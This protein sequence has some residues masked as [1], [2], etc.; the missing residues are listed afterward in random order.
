MPLS[1]Y[2]KQFV[3]H[4]SVLSLIVLFVIPIACAAFIYICRL[5]SLIG[6]ITLEVFLVSW[7]ML[8]R[9]ADPNHYSLLT[10]S[11]FNT[12]NLALV[13]YFLIACIP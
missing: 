2:I 13:L 6:F 12:V 5:W 11:T 9:T 8:Q 10:V 4:K 7:N 1:L 3:L